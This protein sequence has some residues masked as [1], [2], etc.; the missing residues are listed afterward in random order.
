MSFSA[1]EK[2]SLSIQLL[3]SLLVINKD[4]TRLLECN[5]N[6]CSV[7]PSGFIISLL[8]L[9]VKRKKGSNENI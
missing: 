3:Y 7:S 6:S 2:S 9:H 4:E 8:L 1:L 5:S